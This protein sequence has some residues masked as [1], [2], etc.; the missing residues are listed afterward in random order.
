MRDIMVAISIYSSG[1][2]QSLP[3]D[4]NKVMRKALLRETIHPRTANRGKLRKIEHS[5]MPADSN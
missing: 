4:N 1:S 5:K 3:K 2:Y